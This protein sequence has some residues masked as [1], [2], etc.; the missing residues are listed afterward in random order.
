[1]PTARNG[2]A[3]AAVNGIIY[4][5]GGYSSSGITA[6]VEAYNPATDSWS[7]VTPLPFPLYC[8][9]ATAVNDTLYV[10]GGYIVGFS[11]VGSMEALIPF[12]MSVNMYAGLTIYG[13]IGSTYE[14]DCC[15]NLSISNWT[16]LTTM[17]LSNSPC[18][19]IDTNST[20]FS[21]RFY[22]AVQQ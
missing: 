3:A 15:N 16:A 1:M 11:T 4:V 22:R 9:S 10:M 21:H 18:L 6:T 19:Y 12:S 20:Y 8:P 13:Q 2:C 7:T 5:A 14:I 17:G